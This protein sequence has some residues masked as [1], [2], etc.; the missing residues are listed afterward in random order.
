ML[1]KP[2]DIRNPLPMIY[3]AAT[4]MAVCDNPDENREKATHLVKQ[5]AKNGAHII[6]LQE[7]FERPYF[8]SAQLGEYFDYAH[9]FQ[10]HPLITRF[11]ELAHQLNV[12]L[13]ISFFERDGTQYFNS[14]AIIDADGTVLGTYRKVHIPD[15]PGYQEKFYFTPGNL[16][17][18]VWKTAYG[19]I[20]VGICWDQWFPECARAMAL[21]GAEILLYPT[22]IGS[23]PQDT[24]YDSSEHWQTTM[25]GH[26]AANIM[27][28]IASNR[29]GH[30]HVKGGEPIDF[31]GRSFIT[32]E[33]GC[34]MQEASRTNEQI[35][36]QGFDLAKIAKMRRSWGLFRDRNSELY[37][38][39]L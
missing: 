27:P 18:K 35:I 38:H 13:P 9:P 36:V 26:A 37:R 7:L 4:Q 8:C 34:V 22:A 21:I 14:V 20:G 6:L 31:Y 17:F 25:R 3:V 15:G 30:E 39:F 2:T 32:N 10:N 28:V 11:A 1:D 29:I 19:T 33:S 5:A 12:V 24:G 16:G 23:E